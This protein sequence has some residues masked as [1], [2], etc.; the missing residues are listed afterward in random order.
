MILGL[1]GKYRHGGKG[2]DER[3]NG[4]RPEDAGG[5]L[6]PSHSKSTTSTDA[7]PPSLTWPIKCQLS[8][9]CYNF[10]LTRAGHS[11]AVAT[12]LP[13]QEAR[14]FPTGD[15][16]KKRN[17]CFPTKSTKARNVTGLKKIETQLAPPLT[18][19]AE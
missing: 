16:R 11:S 4:E 10:P 6:R 19:H 9:H 13:I 5:S 18:H 1:H 17:R 7:R 14:A 15:G 2:W 8:R 3:N 12:L